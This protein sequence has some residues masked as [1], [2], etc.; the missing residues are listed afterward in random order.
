M[1]RISMSDEAQW[2]DQNTRGKSEETVVEE[3]ERAMVSADRRD[4]NSIL[5]MMAGLRAWV[6]CR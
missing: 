5:L 4:L 1:V 6:Q 2:W 3:G